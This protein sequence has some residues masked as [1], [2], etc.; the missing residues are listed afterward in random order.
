MKPKTIAVIALIVL[1]LILL[2]QYLRLVDLPRFILFPLGAFLG[3]LVGY[4]IGRVDR[5]RK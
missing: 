4:V 5:K 2:T 1:V 3:F